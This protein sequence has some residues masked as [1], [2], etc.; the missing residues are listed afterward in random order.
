MYTVYNLHMSVENCRNNLDDHALH[1]LNVAVAYQI[2]EGQEKG[3]N[4]GYS[5]YALA[6]K[7]STIFGQNNGEARVNTSIIDLMNTAKYDIVLKIECASTSFH[8]SF[9]AF[10]KLRIIV[11]NLV[12]QMTVPLIQNLIHYMHDTSNPFLTESYSLS[13]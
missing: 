3:S 12:A 5:L 13:S 10:V 11:D 4:E 6:E 2:G 1:S 9:D 8:G 7:A